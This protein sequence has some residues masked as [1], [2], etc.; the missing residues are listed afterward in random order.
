MIDLII[1]R[2]TVDTGFKVVAKLG[3]RAP[4]NT[5]TTS[6]TMIHDVSETRRRLLKS[7][8]VD[9]SIYLT[10]TTRTERAGKRRTRPASES[11]KSFND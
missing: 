5:P 3:A 2:K 10:R 11:G 6:E 1:R 4:I 8:N 7:I 9:D